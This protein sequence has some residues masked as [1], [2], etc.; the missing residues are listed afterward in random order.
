MH[1][2][3]QDHRSIA[4]TAHYVEAERILQALPLA[5][6][7]GE[8]DHKLGLALTHAVLAIAA[9]TLAEPHGSQT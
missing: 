3:P 6:K 5:S 4:A 9:A 1:S 8:R 2:S 7:R